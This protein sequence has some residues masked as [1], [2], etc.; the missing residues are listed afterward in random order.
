MKKTSYAFLA[1]LIAAPAFA[2]AGTS[3][4]QTAP[5]VPVGEFELKFQSDIIFNHGGGFNL[6]PHIM[7]GI[8][9]HYLDVDAFVGAGTTDF[10]TGALAKFNLLPDLDGQVGLS[11]LGGFSYLRDEGLNSCL[12]TLGV[13]V[14]K[15]FKA[16]FGDIIPYS[17]FEFETHF[18]SAENYTPLTL[19]LGSKWQPD[20]TKPWSLY[21]EFSISLHRSLYALSIGASYPF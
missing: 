2:G 15:R 12:M 19:L 16:D 13:L 17:A 14:S 7:T 8:W 9:D 10:Q 5:V 20:S 3:L 6:S 1:F 4:M 21:S 18:T 11:F